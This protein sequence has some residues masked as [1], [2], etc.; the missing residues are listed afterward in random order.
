MFSPD[1]NHMDPLAVITLCLEA[2]GN[3]DIKQEGEKYFLTDPYAASVTHENQFGTLLVAHYWVLH[4]EVFLR[5]EV[6]K[7]WPI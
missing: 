3:S 5:N 2:C 7:V 6:C 4:M 1:S